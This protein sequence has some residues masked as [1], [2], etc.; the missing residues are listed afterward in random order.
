LNSVAREASEKQSR[1][2]L[3]A[4]IEASRL[5]QRAWVGPK[6]V[7]SGLKPFDSNPVPNLVIGQ[8]ILLGVILINSGKTPALHF[9]GWTD[10]GILPTTANFSP[11]YRPEREAWKRQRGVVAMMPG[12]TLAMM[13]PESDEIVSQAMIDNLKAERMTLYLFGSYTYSDVFG[14]E[15][16]TKFCMFATPELTAM[17]ACKT[18]GDQN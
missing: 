7:V 2:S 15:H 10:I 8:K 4:S 5:D 17:G 6:M 14:K 3:D 13:A 18:Y 12:G 1:D 11:K 16:F 9:T